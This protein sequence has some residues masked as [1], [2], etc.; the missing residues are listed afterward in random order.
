MPD[1]LFEFKYV[2]RVS[3]RMC[4]AWVARKR[5]DADLAFTE[6]MGTEPESVG[7]VLHITRLTDSGDDYDYL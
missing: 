2:T 1:T 6:V 5:E 7:V 4:F 3:K